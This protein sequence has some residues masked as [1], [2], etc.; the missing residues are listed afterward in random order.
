MT[1]EEYLNYD[2]DTNTRYELVD[3]V[4][5]DTGAETAL[6]ISIVF[7]LAIV[8]AQ[9]GIPPYRLGNKHLIAVSSTKVTA[10]DPDLTVHSEASYHAVIT[11]KQSL[12]AYDQA[13]PLLVVEVVSPGKPGEPNYDR[14]YIE[15]RQEYADRGIPEYWLIDPERHVILVL[16][17][18]GQVYQEQ[19]FTGQGEIISSIFPNLKL[20]VNL[21]LN[22]GR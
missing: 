9:Q 6:N 18:Q 5:V 4:L 19:A 3:G 16:T 17:L 1:F 12:L 14:D 21:I 7:F 11:Q 13:P 15:K 20:T 8:F 2:D 22:A 10:R